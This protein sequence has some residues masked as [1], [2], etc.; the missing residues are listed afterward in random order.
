MSSNPRSWSVLMAVN[1]SVPLNIITVS[2]WILLAF[3]WQGVLAFLHFQ[4]FSKHWSTVSVKLQFL[5][6]LLHWVSLCFFLP[7]PSLYLILKS[8]PNGLFT[9]LIFLSLFR[10][11]TFASA[12]K[13]LLHIPGWSQLCY[14]LLAHW[15]LG[16]Q[17]CITTPALSCISM[18]FCLVGAVQSQSIE[19][20]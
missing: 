12:C 9:V 13:V 3:L 5:Y 17:V 16:L 11:F 4:L 15:V 2:S 20:G 14:N 19:N 1:T 8:I 10:T 18:F 6:F 7:P